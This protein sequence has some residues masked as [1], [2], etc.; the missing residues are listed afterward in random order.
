LA[1]FTLQ[2]LDDFDAARVDG[3]APV[4]EHGR[5]QGIA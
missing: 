4:F 2:G 5:E 3:F 1:T